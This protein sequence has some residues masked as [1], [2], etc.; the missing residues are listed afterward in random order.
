M[1]AGTFGGSDFRSD[2]MTIGSRRVNLRDPIYGYDRSSSDIAGDINRATHDKQYDSGPK[3]PIQQGEEQ[4]GEHLGKLQGAKADYIAARGPAAE[5]E[6]TSIA[7]PDTFA[8][9]IREMQRRTTE[10]A[11]LAT[12]GR[13]RMMA[14]TPFS[15][16]I[17]KNKPLTPLPG[18][19][20]SMGPTRKPGAPGLGG[21]GNNLRPGINPMFFKYGRGR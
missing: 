17:G 1:G 14:G 9:F 21:Y 19:T 7:P 8:P 6:T 11:L 4:F 20:P 3:G 5:D 12:S 16:S 15:P 10:R 2:H 13:D 18:S